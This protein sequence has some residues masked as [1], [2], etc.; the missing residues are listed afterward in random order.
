MTISRSC[1]EVGREADPH[2]LEP[3]FEALAFR[4]G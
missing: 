1:K 2:R 3:S 4:R